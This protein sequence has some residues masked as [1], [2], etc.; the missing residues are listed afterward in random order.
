M[1]K[2]VQFKNV[3]VGGTFYEIKD[4]RGHG[5]RFPLTKVKPTQIYDV[6]HNAKSHE[7]FYGPFDPDEEVLV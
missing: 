4:K 5:W 1:K 7:A 6:L 3:P 2:K